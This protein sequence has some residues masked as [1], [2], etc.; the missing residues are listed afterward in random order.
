M[1]PADFR[2]IDAELRGC[3]WWLV[4]VLVVVLVAVGVGA[5]LLGRWSVTW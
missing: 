1:G 2:G 4:A 5:F 3:F